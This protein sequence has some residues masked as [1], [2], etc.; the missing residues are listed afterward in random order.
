MKTEK[1]IKDMVKSKYTDIALGS[2]SS[3]CSSTSCCGNDNVNTYTVFQDDYSKL[4]GYVKDADLGL[5]CGIPTEFAAIKEGDTVVDLGSGAGNDVFVAQK[6]VGQSGEVIGIDMTEDMINIADKNLQ[7]LG[8]KN[9]KFLLGDIESMPLNSEIADVVISNCVLNLVPDKKKAFNE[10]FRILKSGGHFCISDVVILGELPLELIKSA[11][12]YAGCVSGALQQQEYLNIIKEI[13]FVNIGIKKSKI[14]DLPDDL[15]LQF[16]D[17]NELKSFHENF[18]GLF[19][20]TV[21]ANKI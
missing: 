8:Y 18:K 9:V 4:N 7:K 16:M 15:L 21:V 17:N 11:T 20:I 1:E 14:I 2:I 5:G 10:I 3:C 12:L 13:G 6:L 19:S